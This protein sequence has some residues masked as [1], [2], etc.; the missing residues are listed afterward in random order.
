MVNVT[1]IVNTL[2]KNAPNILF[3][4]GLMEFMK[5]QYFQVNFETCECGAPKRKN[6][7]CEYCE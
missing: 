4:W 1:K 3:S 2:I 6:L 7:R 5:Y